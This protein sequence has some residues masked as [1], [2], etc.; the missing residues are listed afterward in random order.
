MPSQQQVLVLD[1]L[2]RQ[3][4]HLTEARGWAM[5]E[6]AA[7]ALETAEHHSPVT[8]WVDGDEQYAYELSWDRLDPR[9]F[10]AWLDDPETTEEGAS[11]IALLVLAERHGYVVVNRSRK[12]TGFD[13]LLAREGDPIFYF[14]ENPRLRLEISGTQSDKP[15]TVTARVTQKRRQT[16]QSDTTGLPAVIAVVMFRRPQLI[17][18]ARYVTAS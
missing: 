4:G 2:R 7:V 1:A 15:G 6:A 10:Q 13:Y 16:R 9:A 18:S 17:L 5:A 14:Q 8:L 11:G 3:K 12:R